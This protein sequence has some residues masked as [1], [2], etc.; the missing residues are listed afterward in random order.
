MMSAERT[1]FS[2]LFHVED[3]CRFTDGLRSQTVVLLGDLEDAGVDPVVRYRLAS[4]LEMN[5][6]TKY[7]SHAE[8]H[9]S[10]SVSKIS[11]VSR[12]MSGALLGSL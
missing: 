1:L 5:F 6:V 3:E 2:R 11:I 9:P 8:N 12:M 10:E 4:P 7:Q